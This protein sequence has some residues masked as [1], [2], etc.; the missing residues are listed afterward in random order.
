MRYALIMALAITLVDPAEAQAPERPTSCVLLV[1]AQYD[2]CKVINQYQ[3]GSGATARLRQ[4]TLDINGLFELTTFDQSHGLVFGS[5]VGSEGRYRLAYTGSTESEVIAAGSGHRSAQ[6]EFW[7]AGQWFPMTVDKLSSFH[8]EALDLSGKPFHRISNVVE[9]TLPEPFPDSK[10]IEVVGFNEEMELTVVL[11]V[12]EMDENSSNRSM[13]L[14]DIS[15]AGQQGF[16][17]EKPVYG[18]DKVSSLPDRPT[19]GERT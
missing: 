5:L 12:R 4:E 16:G 9:T 13:N 3:C 15:F 17:D 18:C 11:E 7:G 10:G 6:G 2:N 14:V 19:R 8:G 1:T